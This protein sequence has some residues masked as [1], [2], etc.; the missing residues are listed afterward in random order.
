LGHIQAHLTSL[1]GRFGGRIRPDR[2]RFV[3]SDYEYVEMEF[4]LEPAA[5]SLNVDTHPHPPSP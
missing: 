1:W 2:D 3:F 4:D 5:D